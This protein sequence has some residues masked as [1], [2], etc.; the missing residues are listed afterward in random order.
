[1]QNICCQ[2]EMIMLTQKSNFLYHDAYGGWDSPNSKKKKRI[3][4]R[5][6]SNPALIGPY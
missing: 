5:V 3:N 1:M 6:E 4:K 2:K